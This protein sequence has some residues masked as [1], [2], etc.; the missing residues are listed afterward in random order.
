[1]V[2]E[3]PLPVHKSIR[4]LD[5]ERTHR[6]NLGYLTKGSVS[7]LGE[8]LEDR[9]LILGLVNS[10]LDLCTRSIFSYDKIQ[11]NILVL[12]DAAAMGE[13]MYIRSKVLEWIYMK[14]QRS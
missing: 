12:R 1:V 5:R 4:K 9:V 10:N 6:R 8:G 13:N 14:D 2:Q 3:R 11:W 7:A